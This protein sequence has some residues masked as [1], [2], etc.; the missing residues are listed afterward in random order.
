RI[1]LKQKV[2]GETL[3]IALNR[4][5]QSLCGNG[6]QEREVGTEYHL[7]TTKKMDLLFNALA[8][9]NLFTCIGLHVASISQRNLE[10]QR[11][12]SSLRFTGREVLQMRMG[13][14]T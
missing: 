3:S 12:I 5:H 14:M 13:M 9:D 10:S 2:C 11:M 7:L 6:V 1:E 8:G 4:L